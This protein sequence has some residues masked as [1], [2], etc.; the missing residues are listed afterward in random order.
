MLPLHLACENTKDRALTD[1][2]IWYF[3]HLDPH[4]VRVR[5]AQLRLPLHILCEKK[6]HIPKQLVKQFVREFPESVR[7]AGRYSTGS[8]IFK[9]LIELGY[10]FGDFDEDYDDDGNAAI[11]V[12]ETEEEEYNG[13]D[14]QWDNYNLE[15][16][17]DSED[18]ICKHTDRSALDYQDNQAENEAVDES[19][20]RDVDDAVNEDQYSK[21]DKNGDYIYAQPLD[22]ACAVRERPLLEFIRL[23]TNGRPQLHFLCKY[24]RTPWIPTRMNAIQYVAS[25]LPHHNDGMRFYHGVVPFHWIC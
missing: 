21:G 24:S 19:E 16:N 8:K 14:N 5:D 11:T 6:K 2:I 13:D 18:L 10:M 4:A 15:R 1:M 7:M 20:N 9:K 22:V 17:K 23:L 12:N 3:F 25:I